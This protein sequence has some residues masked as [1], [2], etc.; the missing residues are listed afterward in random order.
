[1]DNGGCEYAENQD[2]ARQANGST[3]A[4]AGLMRRIV[5]HYNGSVGV[6]VHRTAEA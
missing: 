5:R 1:M 6:S 2:S 3:K 4:F